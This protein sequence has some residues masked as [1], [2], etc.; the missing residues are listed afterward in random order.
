MQQ[1]SFYGNFKNTP[2][3]LNAVHLYAYIQ[4]V[5]CYI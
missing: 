5:I 4:P 2:H 3:S 1:F